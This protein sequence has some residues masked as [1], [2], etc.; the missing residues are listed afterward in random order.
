MV[1]GSKG[2]QEVNLIIPQGTSLYFEIV[3]TD[4]DGQTVNHSRSS[5]KCKMENAGGEEVKDLSAYC[6]G[7]ARAI[8]VDIPKSFT[9]E[10]VPCEYRWDLIATLQTGT[11][12]R[13]CYGIVEI[14]D[15]YAND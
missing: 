3:Q 2:L 12:M 7:T 5:I 9:A 6:Y 15:T 8:L 13:L 14:V 1:I 11:A 10:L 4:E